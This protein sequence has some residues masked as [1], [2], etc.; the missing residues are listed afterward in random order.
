MMIKYPNNLLELLLKRPDF[1]KNMKKEDFDFLSL[2]VLLSRPHETFIHHLTA[3][4]GLLSFIHILSTNHPYI[5]EHFRAD[6]LLSS[7]ENGCTPLQQ[8]CFADCYYGLYAYG[9]DIL[10]KIITLYPK[11]LKEIP[12]EEWFSNYLLTPLN[13]ASMV[14]SNFS[15]LSCSNAGI[16]LLNELYH[17]VEGI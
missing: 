6:V 11:I 12:C 3:H 13:C 7:L 16:E 1:F 15:L 9:H 17:R 8:L 2:P 10:K 14:T 5:F 4:P